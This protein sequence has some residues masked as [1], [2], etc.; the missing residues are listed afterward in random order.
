MPRR[1]P[2]LFDPVPDPT[3]LNVDA[4]RRCELWEKATQGVTGATTTRNPR[5]MLV[6]EQPGDEEDRQGAPFVGPAGQLLRR[7][8]G[9]AGMTLE[10]IYLTNAVK[11]FYWEPRGPRRIHK[12]PAQRHI[13]ACRAWL[14][15]E[16][17]NAKPAVIVAM[18]STALN[19]VM[20]G[21]M[22]VGDAREDNLKHPAGARVV[23]TY[24]PS[25]ALRAPDETARAELFKLIVS[26]L[27][28]AA[29]IAKSSD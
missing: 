29:K 7:A 14:D 28:K 18:G 27:R 16:I 26:D 3:K 1:Q 19:G 2:P 6:G 10:E 23:A 22:K 9:E 11:H 20:G 21:K 8:I 4:C 13:D 25:A 15:K 17:E 24:H 12:T 5:L